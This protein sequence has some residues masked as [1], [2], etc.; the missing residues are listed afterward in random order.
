MALFFV[1]LASN[2]CLITYIFYKKMP[3]DIII[4]HSDNQEKEYAVYHQQ[5]NIFHFSGDTVMHYKRFS[6]EAVLFQSVF[7]KFPFAKA[8]GDLRTAL[9]KILNAGKEL[10]PYHKFFHRW[11]LLE[12]FEQLNFRLIHLF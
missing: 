12:K 6:K 7:F 4:L 8:E 2:I 3:V 1:L 10:A 11:Q 9:P 5:Q